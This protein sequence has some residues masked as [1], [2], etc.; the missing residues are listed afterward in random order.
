MPINI[1][2][3]A[4]GAFFVLAALT[5]FPNY[6]K[7]SRK[8]AGKPVKEPVGCAHDCLNCGDTGCGQRFY[9]ENARTEGNDAVSPGTEKEEN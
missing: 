5:A 7:L 6:L 3:L 2:I 8:K 4:R 1:F 9:D